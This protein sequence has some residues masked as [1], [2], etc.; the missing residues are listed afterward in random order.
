MFYYFIC[1]VLTVRSAVPQPC[2]VVRPPHFIVTMKKRGK[3]YDTAGNFYDSAG[4]LTT[5]QKNQVTLL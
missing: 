4:T 2:N 5:R 3:I 1:A